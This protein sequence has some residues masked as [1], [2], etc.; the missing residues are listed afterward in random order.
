MEEKSSGALLKG[1]LMEDIH[2]N[3]V[4]LCSSIMKVRNILVHKLKDRFR[5][6]YSTLKKVTI[7]AT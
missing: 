6:G 1:S 3:G 2:G 5:I 7:L 4:I